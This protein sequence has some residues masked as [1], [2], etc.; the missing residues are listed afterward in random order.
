MRSVRPFRRAIVLMSDL[1][2][3][4]RQRRK[5]PGARNGVKSL[6]L[7]EPPRVYAISAWNKRAIVGKNF[8]PSVY[9]P[10]FHRFLQNI[11]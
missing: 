3:P 4:F 1:D 10:P 6:N 2:R 7:L 5:S 8:I 11:P 9:F